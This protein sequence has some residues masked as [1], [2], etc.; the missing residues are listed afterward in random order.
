MSQSMARMFIH[1]PSLKHKHTGHSSAMRRVRAIKMD[2]LS[3][4]QRKKKTVPPRFLHTFSFPS[5]PRRFRPRS[6][7]FFLSTRRPERY[8]SI[9]LRRP[10]VQSGARVPH[11][12]ARSAR[13]FVQPE[14]RRATPLTSPPPNPPT[15]PLSFY[16]IPLASRSP[17]NAGLEPAH[18][19]V[20][21][22]RLRCAVIARHAL[23]E[24][25]DVVFLRR[26]R[27]ELLVRE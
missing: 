19:H 5:S 13:S 17:G 11:T 26:R 10:R 4:L 7:R 18:E 22:E 15:I 12:T 1:T 9:I 27:R 20:V 16:Q 6:S 24:P 14:E 25:L 23:P 21:P 8:V 3:V 2:G